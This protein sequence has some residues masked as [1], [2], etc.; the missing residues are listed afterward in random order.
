M[1]FNL[2]VFG[3]GRVAEVMEAHPHRRWYLAG[4]SLGGTIA[5]QW[6]TD[7]P[8][9][10][11]G[12]VLLA[13][14]PVK[15]L[16]DDLPVL[17]LYGSEDGVLNRTRLEKA[18]ALLPAGATVEQL[19]GGNHANFGSYGAQRGDGSAAITPEAQWDWTRGVDW[20]NEKGRVG[21]D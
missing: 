6:A 20:E 16:P 3:A 2:A 9:R 18:M 10:L 5:A 13:A 15:K 12:L 7:H 8:G 4:H 19:P 14:Y 21:R 11:N 1:P 17:L